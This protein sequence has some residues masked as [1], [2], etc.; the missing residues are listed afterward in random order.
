MRDALMGEM[1]RRQEV[2]REAG[3]LDGVA[4]YQRWRQSDAQLP[5]PTALFVIVDEF[6][7]LL[8]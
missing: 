2:L 6:S 7:E 4:A 8:S 1:N 5:P 3:N